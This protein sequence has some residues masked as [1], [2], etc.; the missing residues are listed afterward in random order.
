[1]PTTTQLALRWNT[2]NWDDFEAE[3]RNN[4]PRKPRLSTPRRRDDVHGESWG[5]ELEMEAKRDGLGAEFGRRNEED[6][7]VTAQSRHAALSKCITTAR[8]EVVVPG[9]S[10]WADLRCS[11]NK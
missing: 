11:G 10:V 2:E 1:M 3:M 8:N 7:A 5:D 4:S 9:T 6:R